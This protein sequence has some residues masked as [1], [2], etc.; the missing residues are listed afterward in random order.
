[1]CVGCL[2][3]QRPSRGTTALDDGCYTLN[4]KVCVSCGVRS[5]PRTAGRRE[6]SEDEDGDLIEEITY[7]HTC[8]EC[9]HIIAV[10]FFRETTAPHAVRY[11]MDCPLCGDGADEKVNRSAHLLVDSELP[12]VQSEGAACISVEIA[13]SV[14]ISM[15]GSLKAIVARKAAVQADDAAEDEWAS[16]DMLEITE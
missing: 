2:L 13:V 7:N 9:G 14:N 11:L 16:D 4:F 6:T 1:M 10:H 3:D 12:A 15:F 8:A 5:Q